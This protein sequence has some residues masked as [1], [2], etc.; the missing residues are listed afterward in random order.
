MKPEHS[1]RVTEGSN[2]S[3]LGRDVEQHDGGDVNQTGEKHSHG[4]DFESRGVVG[5]HAHGERRRAAARIGAPHLVRGTAR[6]GARRAAGT[7]AQS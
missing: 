3:Q 6:A 2:L 5:V 1:L 7:A 4:A